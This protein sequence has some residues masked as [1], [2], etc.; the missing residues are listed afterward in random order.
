MS[1]D[2][3]DHLLSLVGPLI[4]KKHCKSRKPISP[5][6]HL[7]VTLRYL[8]TGDSQQSHT[9]YFRI[10]R[11]TVSNIVKETCNALWTALNQD[12]LKSPSTEEQWTNIADEFEREWNFPH[13]IGALDG[14]HISM[15]CPRNAGSAFFNY[16]NF[17]S[18]VLLATCDAKYCF[19]LIDIGAYGR[20]NDAGVLTDSAFGQAFESDAVHLN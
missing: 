3:F 7:A 5:S 6:E 9:F 18:I 12:Y 1:P 17:H 8:A 14:K 10:G 11:S 13:C 19:T 2:R 15:E 20:E 16:K 4:A